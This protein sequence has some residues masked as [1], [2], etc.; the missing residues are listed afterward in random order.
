MAAG[1]IPKEKFEH[2]KSHKV[3]Y[4]AS[5]PGVTNQWTFHCFR[6]HANCWPLLVSLE[7]GKHY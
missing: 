4:H 1:T 5:F 6:R 2:E 7:G 3:E